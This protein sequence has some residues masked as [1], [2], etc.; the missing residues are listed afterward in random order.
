M[1]NIGRL[2]CIILSVKTYDAWNNRQGIRRTFGLQSWCWVDL[3][4]CSGHCQVICWQPGR[5]PRRCWLT[6]L[7]PCRTRLRLTSLANLNSFSMLCRPEHSPRSMLL[8]EVSRRTQEQVFLLAGNLVSWVPISLREKRGMRLRMPWI[9][10][11]WAHF[12][13]GHAN[14]MEVWNTNLK[15]EKERTKRNNHR[16][17][18]VEGFFFFFKFECGSK[19]H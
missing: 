12:S 18:R 10:R 19:R 2:G 16:E 1:T 8:H 14:N 9:H 3:A 13:T 6:H 17:E 4:A 7:G 11:S 15:E 5:Q